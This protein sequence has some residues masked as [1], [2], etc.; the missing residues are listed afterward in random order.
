[1][2]SPPRPRRWSIDLT[3]QATTAEALGAAALV[4]SALVLAGIGLARLA[5]AHPSD[6]LFLAALALAGAGVVVLSASFGSAVA[7]NARR[8]VWAGSADTSRPGLLLFR[9][10]P[11][12]PRPDAATAV[13]GLAPVRCVVRL[14]PAGAGAGVDGWAGE[15]ARDR[16]GGDPTP[17][18][19]GTWEAPDE[20]VSRVGGALTTRWHPAFFAG[21]PEAASGGYE[22]SWEERTPEGGWRPLASVRADVEYQPPP[23]DC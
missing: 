9:L 5:G 12:A 21:A 16:A 2:A 23:A 13:R 19:G 8:T 18:G 10:E 3:Q 7:R 4:L 22:V 11:V 17:A 15:L 1:M 6:S 20:R 14:L